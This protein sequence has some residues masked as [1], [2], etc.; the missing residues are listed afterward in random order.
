MRVA[1]R[2]VRRCGGPQQPTGQGELAAKQVKAWREANPDRNMA[3]RAVFVAVR[4]GRLIK[5]ENCSE[6]GRAGR[7]HGHHEDYS[8]PLDVV[9]LCGRCHGK[10]HKKNHPASA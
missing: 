4:A 10:R 6:C 7:I 3:H 1:G 9:W 5:P 8:R 2:A